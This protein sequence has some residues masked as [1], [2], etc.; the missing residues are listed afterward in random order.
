MDLPAGG[1]A[2]DR[3]VRAVAAL[4]DTLRRR[5]YAFVRDQEQPVSR[6]RVA[7]AT[8]VS[9]KLAAF[10]LD[11]LVEV[12][13]LRARYEP[14][15]GVRRVGR[16]PKVYEPAGLDVRVSIPPRNYDTLAGIL[17]DAML[18]EHDG[19]ACRE[20]ALRTASARGTEAGTAVRHEA[21]P[22]R[23]GAERALSLAEAALRRRGFE[24]ARDARGGLRFR[25]CPFEPLA[26]KAPALVCGINHGFVAGLLAGLGATAVEAALVQPRPGECCVELRP[27]Q[28]AQRARR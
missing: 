12:G 16:T 27:V 14:A 18:S 13:L 5:M 17:I 4:D 6:E 11:K 9:R 10:H 22:G 15:G 24:P 19:E 21:R 8:G 26:A 20:A 25:N 1:Q 3:S 7:G 2:A 28:P 23:L